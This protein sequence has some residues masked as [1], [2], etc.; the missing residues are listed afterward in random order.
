ML[1][2][3]VD[4]GPEHNS[5]PANETFNPDFDFGDEFQANGTY[6]LEKVYCR[7]RSR[8]SL[9]F[10]DLASS[11]VQKGSLKATTDLGVYIR[12]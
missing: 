10:V 9:V 8:R 5:E 1:R 7:Q 4:F 2:T 3:R 12:S 11:T 6:T